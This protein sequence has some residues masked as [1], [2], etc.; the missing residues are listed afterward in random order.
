MPNGAEWWVFLG[1]VVVIAVLPGPGILYVLARSVQGGRAEGIRSSVGNGLGA[2]VHVA[3]ATVGISAL[4]AASATAFTVVKYAGAAYILYLGIRTLWHMRTRSAT[5]DLVKTS[6]TPRRRPAV[7]QG[8]IAE[9]LNPKTALF[10]L[11]FLPQFVHPDRGGQ[12]AAFVLLGLVFVTITLLTDL[13]VASCV[14]TLSAWIATNP[15]WHQR[16]RPHRTR[17]YAGLLV[18]LAP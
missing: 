16:H 11:A 18:A 15:R 12:T 5:E 1:A 6:A 4:L 10:F 3:A 13:L 17:R 9:A 8:L 14:G 2:L 7:L